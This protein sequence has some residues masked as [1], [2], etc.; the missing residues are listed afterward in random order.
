MARTRVVHL[1]D[2]DEDACRELARTLTESGYEVHSFPSAASFLSAGLPL[3]PDCLVAEIMLEE[4]SGIEFQERV[5]EIDP[6]VSIVF[7]SSN[8]D[9]R[10]IVRVLQA[11]AVD[12]LEKPVT[13]AALVD[14]IDRAVERSARL[15]EVELQRSS[16]RERFGRL[17]PRERAILQHV[18]QGRLNK[19]IAG[20]LDCQEATV[21]VHRSR[22]MRKLG[23]RSVVRLVQFS[24]D[25]GFDQPPVPW[26][27]RGD[28]PSR[29]SARLAC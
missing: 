9:I 4:M 18:L 13:E 16:A 14:A 26:N 10:K 23:V 20:M 21:K 17:T 15:R 12:F 2:Q 6:T 24:R 25:F 5:R 19:Q 22:L 7:A 3:R 1:V 27:T 28:D 11:G 8:G 29:G